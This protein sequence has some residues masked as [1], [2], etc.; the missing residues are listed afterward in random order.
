MFVSP[1]Q[2]LRVGPAQGPQTLL[3]E[4]SDLESAV[5]PS[6]GSN[7]LNCE[8]VSNASLCLMCS[9]DLQ[10]HCVVCGACSVA[11]HAPHLAYYTLVWQASQGLWLAR[12][13]T[14]LHFGV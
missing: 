7:R 10:A 12:P 1:L 9:C 6:Q 13:K 5:K 2:R 11:Q 3:G 4:P 14:T 8:R